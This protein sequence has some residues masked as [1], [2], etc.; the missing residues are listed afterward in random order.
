MPTLILESLI[1]APVDLCFDLI[2]DPRIQADPGPKTSGP[3]ELGQTVTFESSRFGI[4]QKLT[5]KVTEFERPNR[6]VDDLVDGK[7]R[8]FKHVHEFK[9]RDAGTLIRDTVTWISSLGPFTRV[10]DKLVVRRHLRNLIT[11]RNGR[12]REIAEST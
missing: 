2:R 6:F 4:R 8:E 9:G 5:V 11:N 10:L 7:F 1:K 12:L 3:F